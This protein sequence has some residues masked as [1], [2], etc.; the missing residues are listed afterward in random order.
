MHKGSKKSNITEKSSLLK[1]FKAHKMKGL[2]VFEIAKILQIN[3][4]T[5]KKIS[6]TLDRKKSQK[7]CILEK[8]QNNPYI[9]L[10]ILNLNELQKDILYKSKEWLTQ[11]KPLRVIA[12]LKNNPKTDYEKLIRNLSSE[13][14]DALEEDFANDWFEILTIREEFKKF[15]KQLP[16]IKKELERI[17]ISTQMYVHYSPGRIVNISDLKAIKSQIPLEERYPLPKSATKRFMISDQVTIMHDAKY[18]QI[19][20]DITILENTITK[21]RVRVIEE[22]IGSLK[23]GTKRLI[24]IY[25][26]N[27][28][29]NNELRAFNNDEDLWIGIDQFFAKQYEK[30]L[31]MTNVDEEQERLEQSFAYEEMQAL[32]NQAFVSGCG[33]R[34]G[35]LGSNKSGQKMA[36][37]MNLLK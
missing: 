34:F 26:K 25:F 30:N 31:E 11:I 20:N 33:K 7:Q 18:L 19:A 10:N 29:L 9:Q 15:K 14:I 4:S 13:T 22:Y 28:I 36:Y 8:F 2:K 24:N 35:K 3:Y 1:S 16:K 32:E 21:L 37:A 6:A 23:E 12:E 27:P 17:Q 5:A